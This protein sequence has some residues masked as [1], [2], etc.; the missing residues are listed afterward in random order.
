MYVDANKIQKWF[1]E[2]DEYF[3][4]HSTCLDDELKFWIESLWCYRNRRICTVNYIVKC[5]TD[6]TLNVPH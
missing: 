3:T 2:I 5:K 1:V 4:T 6:E